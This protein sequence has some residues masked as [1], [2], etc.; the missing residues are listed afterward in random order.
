MNSAADE[1]TTKSHSGRGRTRRDVLGAALLG[2]A[3]TA[4]PLAARPASAAAA[5]SALPAGQPRGPMAYWPEHPF[6]SHKLLRTIGKSNVRAADF[7]EAYI[8]A[9][10][11][12]DT[13]TDDAMVREFTRLGNS[14][15]DRAVA[16][17]KRDPRGAREARRR[18]AEYLRAAEFC[19]LPD[20]QLAAKV[21]LYRHVRRTFAEAVAHEEPRVTPIQVP[22]ERT[23]LYGYRV[24]PIGSS[25]RR[26]HPTVILYGGFD[27]VGEEVYMWVGE[28]LA[29]RG[30]CAV[31]VDGPG[32][33][34]SLRLRGI[35]S[36]YDYEVATKAVI[37]YL[38]RQRYVDPKRIGLIGISLG[39]YYA[40][41][42]AL[43]RRLRATV[44]WTGIWDAP[45][46]FR[47]QRDPETIAFFSR[48]GPWV[49][50]AKSG[51]DA[52][53]KLS[54]FRMADVVDGI[55]NNILITHGEDDDLAPVEQAY[56]LY[57]AIR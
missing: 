5:G 19:L 33:G 36:R 57:E 47:T 52:L 31:V 27:S 16:I 42:S 17:D 1:M 6:Y 44:C 9:Q 41:R 39:G 23:A 46:G 43:D 22:Y 20:T 34:A 38:V 21:K 25:R 3:A 26:R 29:R 49:L 13:P 10:G 53:R 2:A 11:I 55:R 24:D 50:G 15:L 30:V 37:D 18:A 35:P 28:E 14:L 48:Q 40:A 51:A 32:Q 4:I 56:Q 12:G 54:R 45:A 7:T 8:A